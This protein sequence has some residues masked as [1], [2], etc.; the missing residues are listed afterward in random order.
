MDAIVVGAG[1]G[2]CA[3]AWH[4]R[5]LG[6][7]V[8]LVERRHYPADKL[9]GE[10]LSYDGLACLERM[11]TKAD[12][13]VVGQRV[14]EVLISGADGTCWQAELPAPGL[15][16]SR[17]V[18][19]ATLATAC[20][21]A[22]VEVV[23]GVQVQK[24]VGNWAG[25]FD[26]H[27]RQGE[28][29]TG[30]LVVG[31]CGRRGG[32]FRSEGEQRRSSRWMA[33]KVQIAWSDRSRRVELHGFPGGYAGL[34]AVEGGKATLCLMVGAEAFQAAGGQAEDFADRVMRANPLLAE[35]LERFQPDWSAMLAVADL[36]FGRGQTARDGVLLLGDAAGSINPLCGDGMSMALRGGE[37]LAPLADRFLRGD[38][39]GEMLVGMWE[40]VWQQEFKG[41][42]RMGRWLEWALLQ[43]TWT[44]WTLKAFK[45]WPWLGQ[46]ALR[47]SRG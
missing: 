46:T 9:C 7:Q 37:F 13:A 28:R 31:A 34:G 22:G 6:W 4:L 1:P 42:L 32:L 18:M 23:H 40:R 41:R 15:G 16:I 11:G 17:S 29:Y 10:F 43:P 45:A 25:G 20:K 47:W 24:V 38:L 3:A 35:R 30:R 5:R 44:S 2:G 19:D 36:H 33:L 14:D 21:A 8:L 12:L 27:G 39:T 26:V